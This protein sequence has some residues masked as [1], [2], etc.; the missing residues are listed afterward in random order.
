MNSIVLSMTSYGERLK[1]LHQHLN[2]VREI[3]FLFN[4]YVG[5]N[6]TLNPELISFFNS[7]P[8]AKLHIVKDIGP[9]TKSYYAL[10]EFPDDTIFLLDDD[11]AY[12]RHWIMYSID[13]FVNNVNKFPTSIIGLIARRIIINKN[14]ELE[15]M[16]YGENQTEFQKTLNY[17]TGHSKPFEASY[18]NIVLSGGPGSFLNIRQLHKDYFDVDKYQSMCKS[19]D[20]M[21]NWIQSVRIGYKHVGLHTVMMHPGVIPNTQQ[22]GL[23]VNFNSVEHEQ[24][25][26][27]SF[28]N[29]YPE[30]MKRIILD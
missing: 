19:H 12:S 30:V 8:N 26:F 13:S 24:D 17:P 25:I 10:Q 2:W 3:P 16:Q 6:E 21:W 9:L 28:L 5:D 29:E 11:L 18:K 27:R 1:I 14:Y 23:G 15:I 22:Y 4:L 7:T 20:E